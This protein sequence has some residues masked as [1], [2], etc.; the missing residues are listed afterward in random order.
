M[1]PVS[2]VVCNCIYIYGS[3]SE[4]NILYIFGEYV[5]NVSA[6]NFG[7]EIFVFVSHFA[8]QNDPAC[9]LTFF[10]QSMHKM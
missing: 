2:E 8:H 5:V 1:N 4:I 6:S 10:S 9:G 7:I 3:Y